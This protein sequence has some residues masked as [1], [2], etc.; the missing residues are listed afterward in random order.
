[1]CQD[2]CWPEPCP[3][4]PG[5]QALAHLPGADPPVVH[6]LAGVPLLGTAV[7]LQL[8]CRQLPGAV[9]LEELLSSDPTVLDRLGAHLLAVRI[10]HPGELRR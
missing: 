8:Q 6:Q 7:L 3:A 4:R 5:S 9:R 1:M 2:Q 10:V